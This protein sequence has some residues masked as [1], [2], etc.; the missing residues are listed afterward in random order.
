MKEKLT[1]AILVDQ[2]LDDEEKELLKEVYERLEVFKQGCQ[3]YHEEVREARA[4]LNQK[5]PKAQPDVL[6]LQTLISTHTNCVADQMQNMPEPRL[7]PERPDQQELAD[8]LQDAVRYVVYDVNNYEKIHRRRA[9]DLYGAGTAVLQVFWDPT[10]SRG[11]GDVAIIRWPV[12]AFLWDP[13]EEN[14]QDARALF[15]ISWHPMSWYLAHYPEKGQYVKADDTQ[16]GD[17]G[18]SDAQ[19]KLAKS[20]DEARAM[21]LEY[22]YRTFDAKTKRY[23]INVAYVAGGALLEHHKD[24]YEHGRYPFVLDVHSLIEGQPVGHSMVMELA[25]MMRYINRY[26]H[27]MDTNLRMASKAR[28]LV[29]RNSGINKSDLADWNNDMIEGDSVEPGLDYSWLQHAPMP[30]GVQNMMVLFQN[31]L[32]NDSGMNS[33]SRGESTGGIVSGKAI[34]ALQE[35]GGKISGLRTDTLNNGFREMIEQVLWLMAQFY[36][37]KRMICITGHGKPAREITIDAEKFFGRKRGSALPPPPY[38]VQV[39]VKLKDPVRIEAQNQMFMEAYTMAA[40]A[41]QFFPL[42]ALFEMLNIDG[43]D[44]LLPVIRENETIQQQMQALQQQNAEMQQQM[45]QMSKENDSLRRTSNQMTAA[46]ANLNASG[47]NKQR[48]NLKQS[49][50]NGGVPT[51]DIAVDQARQSLAGEPQM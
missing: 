4:I 1:E 15:K 40:Q 49:L 48:G 41:Q 26:A 6:Q 3:S 11:K 24:L 20:T 14:I 31:D 16:N 21:L 35:A 44:R 27:Y 34:T 28:M 29:R 9:D 46:L 43:K 8:N 45:E 5:D 23:K 2:P 51:S 12:E 17:L 19:R 22:W 38:L 10:L 42:S 36:D 50:E 7:L 33:Y 18:K 37:D 47:A 13:T 39:E 32:K 30:A 25:D